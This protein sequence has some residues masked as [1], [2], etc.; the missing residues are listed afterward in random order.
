MPWFLV[1]DQFH[2]HPDVLATSL[3]ARGLWVTA[4]SW[5]S[6]RH[7]DVV[8]DHVL[9]SFGSTP[10][11]A[12][13][14]ATAR[15]WKRVR[16]GYRFTQEGLCRI[17]A[18]E[19]VDKL[20]EQKTERQRRWRE[21]HSRRSVDASTDASTLDPDP[22]RSVVNLVGSVADHYA[23]E[24]DDDLI[25]T[26]R[27]LIKTRTGHDIDAAWARKIAGQIL[28]GHDPRNRAAYCRSA[29]EKEP[30]PRT[31]FLPNGGRP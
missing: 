15:V 21:R 13:E 5:S 27:R 23:R 6:A 31:R 22:S 30:D 16:G 11:L 7:I 4:G 9:A 8:P 29:I 25:S 14:L 19:T 1:D 10:K 2:S 20:R 28:N 18:R 26:I 24:F 17:P 12:A 3:A